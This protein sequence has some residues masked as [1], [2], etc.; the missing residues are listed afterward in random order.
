MNEYSILMAQIEALAENLRGVKRALDANQIDPG[1][2][3]AVRNR[4]ERLINK[5][6]MDVDRLRGEVENELMLEGCWSAFRDIRQDCVSIFRESLAFLE[7]ALIRSAG[8]DNGICQVADFL[9]DDLSHRTDIPWAR[10]TILAEEEFFARMAEI[11]RLRFPEFSI[12]NL[13]VTGHEFGHLV[14][15]ELRVH[16]PDGTYRYP[17]QEI[18]QREGQIEPRNEAFLHEHFAD[19]FA[20]YTLGPAFAC[21]CILLRFDPGVAYRDGREHPGSAKRAYFILRGLGKMDEAEGGVVRP[22][23]GIIE[24][25][26]DLWR[27]NLAAAGQPENLDQGIVPQLNEWLEELY[28]LLDTE[29]PPRA[30]Y[31]GWLRA[32]RLSPELLSNKEAGRILKDEDTLADVINA[33]W[34]CRI[35][36]WDEGSYLVRKIGEKADEL[37][38][39]IIRL[40]S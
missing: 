34:M 17:F 38:H 37:C 23:G 36:H 2:R 4:F 5:Q 21:V 26:W 13:P 22:Y 11:I 19:A 24:H 39:E 31:Q 1:L 32:Q 10:F 40:R 9:L 20:T 30:R 27:Q 29:L 14:G 3:E 6:Q 15:Q 7:G 33:A 12:W 25:L 8:M 18:L 28:L 35:Q 16:K